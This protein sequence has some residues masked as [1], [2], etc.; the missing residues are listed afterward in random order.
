[1]NKPNHKSEMPTTGQDIYYG[2][3]HDHWWL[4]GKYDIICRF[5]QEH[6]AGSSIILDVGCGPGNLMEK[7]SPLTKGQLVGLDLALKGLQYAK[8][9][10]FHNLVLGDMT[11]GPFKEASIDF[12][13][14]VDICEH[15]PDDRQLLRELHCVL[16]PGG[17]LLV[18]VP[19]HPILWGEHDALFGHYRRY[20]R[21]E[22]RSRMDGA[23]FRILKISYMQSLFF[24]PLLLLR[25][26]KNVTRCH[27]QDFF[28]FPERL[29]R[30]L[31]RLVASEYGL[32]RKLSL[33]I[34]TNILCVVEKPDVKT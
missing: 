22:L 14:A 29:N 30:L 19:A 12:I 1:M 11:R 17:R 3:G 25:S 8:G 4:T 5:F 21:E 6:R 15:V 13:L 24:L 34:G 27:S 7:I 16:K 33:P 32:L 18:V 23:G 10:N 20:Y 31:H 26:I 28:A 2:V 9:N